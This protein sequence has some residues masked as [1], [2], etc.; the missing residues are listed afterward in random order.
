MKYGINGKLSN[1][2]KFMYS[3]L[4]R[5]VKMDGHLS[6]YFSLNTVL[7]ANCCNSLQHQDLNLVL[8]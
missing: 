4:K 8:L 1:V 3:D 7:V 5:C 2:I 6:E